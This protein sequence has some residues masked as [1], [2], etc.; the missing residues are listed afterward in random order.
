MT[1]VG[2]KYNLRTLSKLNFHFIVYGICFSRMVED[3]TGL[4]GDN[5]KWK[6]NLKGSRERKQENVNLINQALGNI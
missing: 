1:K 5:T 2:N 3:V 6:V 4:L